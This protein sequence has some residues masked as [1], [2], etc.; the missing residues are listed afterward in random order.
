MSEHIM[1]SKECTG[2]GA[3]KYVCPK[4]AISMKKDEK[5]FWNWK[6]EQK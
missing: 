3:C 2:C 5:G 4:N 6:I 1:L